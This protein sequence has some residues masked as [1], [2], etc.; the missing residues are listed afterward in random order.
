M[1]GFF[2]GKVEKGKNNPAVVTDY[3]AKGGRNKIVGGA[4]NFYQ[5][6]NQDV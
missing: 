1:G 3:Q 4:N 2:K 5:T 6:T